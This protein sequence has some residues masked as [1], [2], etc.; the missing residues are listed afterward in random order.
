MTTMRA[1]LPLTLIASRSSAF[2]PPRSSRTK[3]R[4]LRVISENAL[5]FSSERLFREELNI[6]YDSKCNVC[7]LEIDF[8]KRRDQRLHGSNNRL[9]FTDLE[10]NKYNEE[11]PVNG[12][13]DYETGMKAMHAIT[14]DGKVLV[15]VPVFQLAYQQVGLGWLFAVA[16]VPVLRWIL[17]RTYDVFAVYRTR[18][19]RGESVPELVEAYREK[20]Q[21]LKEQSD[22]KSC[23]ENFGSAAKSVPSGNGAALSIK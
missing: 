12:R 17:D 4:F 11:D 3:S 23:N 8:L 13:V 16:N 21:L 9:K 18:L 6:L 14:P 19:T 10:S 20:K 7:K 1:F 15:G 22:C 2:I 5:Y